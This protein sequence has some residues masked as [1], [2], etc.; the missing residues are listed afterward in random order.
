MSVCKSVLAIFKQVIV[1][2]SVTSAF[3]KYEQL[4]VTEVRAGGIERGIPERAETWVEIWRWAVDGQ[5]GCWGLKG[6]LGRDRVT[7]NMEK[8]NG[9][10]FLL[11]SLAT[12]HSGPV[13]TEI[14]LITQGHWGKHIEFSF[15]LSF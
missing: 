15:P 4:D 6:I 3:F 5:Q 1:L 8:I 11:W 2:K 9:S 10:K 14:S 13:W 12:K 7:G